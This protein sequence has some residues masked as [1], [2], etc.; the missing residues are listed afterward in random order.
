MSEGRNARFVR[1][2][3]RLLLFQ[4]GAAAL[5]TGLAGWAA[6][7]VAGLVRERDALAERIA[8]LEAR[9]LTGAYPSIYEPDAPPPPA[10]SATPPVSQAPAAAGPATTAPAP[11]GTPAPV[12][13]PVTD[14]PR[15]P[16]PPPPPVIVTVPPPPPPPTPPVPPS[17]PRDCQSVQRQP[18]VCVPPFRRTPVPGVCLDGNN[19]PLRCPPGTP[20]PPRE[21]PQTDPRQPQPQPQ[22]VI[23]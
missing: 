13:T 19:R 10:D 4:V 7:E 5:A 23:R 12:P 16:P 3:K 18:I 1:T 8:Q 21:Q 2:A 6:L 9:P 14:P 17:P 11:P 20:R 15:G 22:P